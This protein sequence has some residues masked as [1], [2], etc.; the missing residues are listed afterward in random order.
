MR[1]AAK[2][3][4]PHAFLSRQDVFLVTGGRDGRD[5]VTNTTEFLKKGFFFSGFELP[6]GGAE[7]HCLI[8]LN[9]THVLLAGGGTGRPQRAHATK[10]V[11]LWE[12]GYDQTTW[13]QVCTLVDPWLGFMIVGQ[14][15]FLGHS[16]F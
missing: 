12:F 9:D 1:G 2:S 11:F 7:G 5:A 15:D 8:K 6:S 10:S 14:I 13:K 3:Q 16:Y 4:P